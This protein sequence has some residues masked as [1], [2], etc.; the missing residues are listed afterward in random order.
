[1]APARGA[2]IVA[3]IEGSGGIKQGVCGLTARADLRARVGRRAGRSVES[4]GNLR[5]LLKERQEAM[6]HGQNVT[7]HAIDTR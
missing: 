7:V 5:R 2:G 6:F 1:M 4:N 3:V